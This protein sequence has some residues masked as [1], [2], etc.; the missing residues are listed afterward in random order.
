[1][2]A[3]LSVGA[4]SLFESIGRNHPEWV[5]EGLFTHAVTS[6]RGVRELLVERL[7]LRTSGDVV[8]FVTPQVVH[9][10]DSWRCDVQLTWPRATRRVE[11]KLLA[12]FTRAQQGA[13]ID[14]LVA[15][16]RTGR[17]SVTWAELSEQTNHQGLRNL[18]LE[19]QMF[20]LKETLTKVALTR[21]LA[22]FQVGGRGAAWPGMYGFL[23]AVDAWLRHEM[24]SMYRPNASWSMAKGSRGS[25]PWYGYYF[26]IA[27]A[28][29]WL[30]FEQ[31][32]EPAFR[33]YQGRTEVWR[34]RSKTF[35]AR[36]IAAQVA[37]RC[38]QGSER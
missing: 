38:R 8:P 22:S 31:G 10:D 9:K 7:G 29:Y 2:T 17:R 35:N 13:Q 15:L 20:R 36:D 33:L 34:L 25:S 30:G 14:L 23:C 28:Q 18:L 26:S 6:E 24:P 16:R 21:E 19:V 37:T 27:S 11:L 4:R 12:P 32:T 1:M 5:A 3:A